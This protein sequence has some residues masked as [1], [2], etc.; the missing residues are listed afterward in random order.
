MVL[1]KFKKFFDPKRKLDPLY[2]ICSV[3]T[4]EVFVFYINQCGKSDCAFACLA[5]M[6]ANY[7]HDRNYLFL[8][9]QDKQYSFKDLIGIG[10]EY[11]L[12]L[13]GVKF[14][15]ESEIIHN[16]TFP[17][18][19]ILENKE[20]NTRHSVLLTKIKNA[21]VYFYDPIAGKRVLPL[22][23]FFELWS[24]QAL[25]FSGMTKTKCPIIPPDF[26]AKEDK[27]ILPFFQ[28]LSGLSLFIGSYFINKDTEI[29]LPII[30]F[31]AFI[32]FELFFRASLVKAMK[33][34]DNNIAM[35]TLKVDKG[36]YFDFY[37]GVEKYRY[38]SFCFFT[39]LIFSLMIILF[40]SF[41][42]ILN[43]V[44]NLIYV[45]FALTV[46]VLESLFYEPFFEK[47][48][49]DIESDEKCLKEAENVEEYVHYAA[50]AR[51]KAYHL[52]LSKTIM[53]YL[54]IAFF[55]ALSVFIMSASKVVS[56]TYIVFYLSISM[57]LKSNFSKVFS[58]SKDAEQYDSLRLRIINSVEIT[59][60]N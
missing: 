6:L 5:M 28:I 19:V 17:I 24:K 1:F 36:Q 20:E 2:S 44:Y 9:H 21:K 47:R 8:Q 46:A 11:N 25:I 41:I 57:Y 26:I 29:I 12:H 32:V 50:E 49:K 30:F 34:M 59:H 53:S 22:A 42:L 40:L 37:Q 18:I 45:L 14:E 16:K 38:T 43:S 27:I 35:Y 3:S 48:N 15:D 55:L 52:S 4:K 39:N 7:H 58:Y 10:G 60:S 56:I 51:E 23:D 13:S 31:S 33:K 54:T